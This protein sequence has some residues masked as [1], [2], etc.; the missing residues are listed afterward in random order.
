MK[1]SET[2]DPSDVG[3]DV[4]FS[5]S[6]LRGLFRIAFAQGPFGV[7][8]GGQAVNYWAAT[9]ADP[10]RLVNLQPM[11]SRD[12]DFFGGPSEARRLAD[13]LGIDGR[14]ND[15]LDP[16][17]NAAVLTATL[18]DGR[19]IVI[20]VLT[21]S[22]GVSGSELLA[23]ATTVKAVGADVRVIHPM[24]LLESK[25]TCLRQLPQRERQDEK[26]IR[27]L[28]HV[29]ADQ[30]SHLLDQPRSLFRTVERYF[31]L[32]TTPTGRHATSR[33]VDLWGAVPLASMRDDAR[34]AVFFENRLPQMLRE[35]D[36]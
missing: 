23:T 26:H 3:G 21:T 6:D 8:I 36:S 14:F 15:G 12:L 18:E 1:P 32:L 24:L 33:G 7:L 20:D 2:R 35:L 10:D 34:Y 28:K 25:L 31:R 22:L 4:S 11:T 16:S 30:M 13:R 5:L 17:P 29:L 9:V 19:R 27:I